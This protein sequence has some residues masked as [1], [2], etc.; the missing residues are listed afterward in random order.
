M[1]CNWNR[2]NYIVINLSNNNPENTKDKTNSS[3]F[4]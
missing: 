1:D 3:L 4:L 2:I